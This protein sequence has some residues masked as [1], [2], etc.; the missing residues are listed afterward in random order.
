MK[1]LTKE[2]IENVMIRNKVDSHGRPCGD[3]NT[4]CDS[5]GRT[6]IIYPENGLLERITPDME[7]TPTRFAVY[8]NIGTCF[9]QRLTPFYEKYGFAVHR[10]SQIVE[11]FQKNYCNS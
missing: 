5:Y 6:F 3:I 9:H 8:I 2:K 11:K 10:M 7:L 4:M 1:I